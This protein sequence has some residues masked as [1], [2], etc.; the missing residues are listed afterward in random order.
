MTQERRRSAY[1]RQAEAEY[2]ALF[3]NSENNAA[4]IAEKGQGLQAYWRDFLQQP[5]WYIPLEP[6]LRDWMQTQAHDDPQ[7]EFMRKPFSDLVGGMLEGEEIPLGQTGPNFDAKREQRI[8]E[9]LPAVEQVIVHHSELPVGSDTKAEMRKIN[10]LGFIRQFTDYY[11]QESGSDG[12]P[13]PWYGKP[14][15]SGHFD[16]QGKQVFYAYNAMVNPQGEATWLLENPAYTLWHAGGAANTNSAGLV[17]LG[18]YE[19]DTPPGVQIATLAQII[20]DRY[21]DIAPENIRGHKEVNP[22]RTCPGD[23]FLGETGWKRALQDAVRR[24][25]DQKS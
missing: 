6:F 17:L 18:N 1:S 24:V 4:L 12:E 21:S 9:G 8:R 23:K 2:L 22:E 19:H 11:M 3:P 14:V 25:S 7:S 15:W 20:T 10:A 16:N 13:N 5:D